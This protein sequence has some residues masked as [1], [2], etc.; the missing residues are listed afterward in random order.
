MNIPHHIAIIPDGNRR[1]AR[2]KRIKPWIGHKYGAEVFKKILRAAFDLKISYLSFWGSSLDN[3]RKRSSLEIKFLLNLFKEKFAE[4]LHNEDIH[5]HKVKINILGHWKKQFPKEVSAVMEEVI[6]ATQNYNKFFLN[7]FIAYSGKAEML[8]AIEEII[9]KEKGNPA[10]K[11]TSVLL[12]K[13][14]FTKDLPPVDYLIRTG[15]EPHNSDGFM[16]WDVADAQLYFS[17]KLWP[18]FTGEDFKKAIKEYSRRRRR[19]GK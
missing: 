3:L 15:G 11:I 5:K 2:K 6:K 7:F 18:D 1:W 17:N 14:L 13:H 8:R 4:L 19:F 16:M 10:P 9:K 12:K